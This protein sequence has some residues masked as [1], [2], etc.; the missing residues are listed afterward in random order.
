M[1]L[2]AEAKTQKSTDK[3]KK[4][5]MRDTHG[6]TPPRTPRLLFISGGV[7]DEMRIRYFLSHF[8]LSRY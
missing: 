8:P 7:Y 2:D 4:P 1:K 3:S 5:S 6:D